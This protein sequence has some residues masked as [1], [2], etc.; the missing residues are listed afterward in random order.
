MVGNVEL[1]AVM[2]VKVQRVHGN[3][4]SCQTEALQCVVPEHAGNGTQPPPVGIKPLAVV[5]SKPVI[6][7][8]EGL[9]HSIDHVTQ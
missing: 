7:D 1:D 4:G 6:R 2:Q 3:D 9:V 5:D 8:F